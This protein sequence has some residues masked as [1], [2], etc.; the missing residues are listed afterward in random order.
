MASMVQHFSSPQVSTDFTLSLDPH[1]SSSASFANYST[2]SHQATTSA[3]R[4]PPD[5]DTS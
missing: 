4:P 2:T 5:I 3:S 1:S